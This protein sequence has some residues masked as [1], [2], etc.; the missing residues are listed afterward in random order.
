MRLAMQYKYIF[1]Y[2]NYSVRKPLL[3]NLQCMKQFLSK[4]HLR[5]EWNF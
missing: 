4:K 2:S 3:S 1:K 5:H